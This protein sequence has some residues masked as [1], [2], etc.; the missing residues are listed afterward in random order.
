MEFPVFQFVPI[1]PC[2]FWAAVKRC[3][4][5]CLLLLC[6]RYLHT[7]IRSPEPSLLQ[8][9][10]LQLSQPLLVWHMLHSLNY[11]CDPSLN[12]LQ[13]VHVSLVLGSPE[14]DTA[15]EVRSHECFTREK[16][17]LA[18]NAQ[19]VV[20]LCCTCALLAHGQLFVHQEPWVLFCNASFWP[21]MCTSA[22]G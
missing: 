9:K 14:P 5:C 17:P 19:D 12:L 22:R 8:A 11:L 6:S 7:L 2:P 1:A 20:G 13:Y 16:V 18:G 10:Q 21:S 3:W 15:L 4:F